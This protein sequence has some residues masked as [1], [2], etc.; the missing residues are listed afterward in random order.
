MPEFKVS[1]RV[2]VEA[3]TPDEARALVEDVLRY[4]PDFLSVYVGVVDPV[5]AAQSE[6]GGTR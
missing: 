4:D 5:K 2:R 1:A 3:D 6:Q